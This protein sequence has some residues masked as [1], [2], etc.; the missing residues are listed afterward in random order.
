MSDLYFLIQQGRLY[1]THNN[2]RVV[3]IATQR[4][5]T[6]FELRRALLQ[7]IET[8]NQLLTKYK[9]VR[10][11]SRGQSLRLTGAVDTSKESVKYKYMGVCKIPFDL[12]RDSSLI[13]RLFDFAE[14]D[15]FLVEEVNYCSDWNLLTVNGI[16][17][18]RESYRSRTVS[19]DSYQAYLQSL[20]EIS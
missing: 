10:K 19:A 15:L 20:I 12:I 17:L 4:A 14:A 2:D 11:H 8:N 3:V 5:D 13:K 6:S 7:N 18:D 1:A 16:R 9:S